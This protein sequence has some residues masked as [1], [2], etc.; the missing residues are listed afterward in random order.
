M[1]IN[2]LNHHIVQI[3][4][5]WVDATKFRF[6]AGVGNFETKKTSLD[7]ERLIS[8]E[9]ICYCLHKTAVH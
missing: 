6:S 1:T 2:L 9:V 5:N 4:K 7:M 3:R 8:L